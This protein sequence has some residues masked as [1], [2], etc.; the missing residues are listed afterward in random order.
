MLG[1]KQEVG[2][3]VPDCHHNL[4]RFDESFSNVA[5]V[6]D[7]L[8]QKASVGLQD[9]LDGLDVDSWRATIGA[10]PEVGGAVPELLND[11]RTIEG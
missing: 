5:N 2:G 7:S 3:A 4:R 8:D 1:T 9:A 10:G 6:L 11:L